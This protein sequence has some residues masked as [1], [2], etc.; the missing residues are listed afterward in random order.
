ME[1]HSL[2]AIWEDL[3]GN[4]NPNPPVAAASD[5][6]SEQQDEILVGGPRSAVSSMQLLAR[7]LVDS[8]AGL[9]VAPEAMPT[10]QPGPP[11][12]HLEEEAS[13]L[14][15]TLWSGVASPVAQVHDVSMEGMELSLRD[16]VRPADDGPL[17]VAVVA[18]QQS[19][20]I[21]SGG[22]T[23]HPA[24]RGFQV[25][26][27]QRQLKGGSPGLVSVG[28]WPGRG[29][30]LPSDGTESG[31]E[32][33]VAP[34]PP[35]AFDI[36]DGP[37]ELPEGVGDNKVRRAGRLRW[38]RTDTYQRRVPLA[39]LLSEGRAACGLVAFSSPAA[40]SHLGRYGSSRPRSA[41]LRFRRCWTPS[42]K[43]PATPDL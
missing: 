42:E 9:P 8:R 23:L 5:M 1:E 33:R 18:V 22:Q 27:A 15:L 26:P 40:V 3:D 11:W 10:G 13:T 41:G 39:W 6:E 29:P 43:G 32:P 30:R 7:H 16:S 20:G 34:L 36:A 25:P 4:L 21:L 24:G 35:V 2:E 31:E 12:P 14:E 19:P 17:P 28:H 37:K 38:F